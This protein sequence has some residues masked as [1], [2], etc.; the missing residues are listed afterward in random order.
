MLGSYDP[1]RSNEEQMDFQS[2]ILSRFDLIFK[3]IDPRDP[4]ID[5]RLAQ[6]VVT[7]HK[8]AAHGGR[9]GASGR[10]R[11]GGGPKL[12]K[13]DTM[14]ATVDRHFISKY[15]SYAKATCHTT[16][17]EEAAEILLDFYVQVRREA[18]QH[19]LESV[20][21]GG[22]GSAAPIIQVT[23]RQLESLVRITESL[24]KMRLDPRA[25]RADAE[26]AIRLFRAATVDAIRSGVTESQLSEGQTELVHKIEDA[27]RRRVAMGATVEHNR[28]QSELRKFGFDGSLIDRAIFAMVRREELEWRKQRTLLYR[29]R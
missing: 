21:T 6:H 16:I 19:T 1:L 23:A 13:D 12:S 2:S 5:S 9:E 17:S 4:R 22:G 27:L 28:L 29:A 7:L 18:H 8:G 26:E 25:S 10:P 20:A 24:A 15:I 11:G 3:V 14:T